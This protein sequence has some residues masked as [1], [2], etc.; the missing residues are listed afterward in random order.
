LTLKHHHF[1]WDYLIDILPLG[2]AGIA[3]EEMVARQRCL[4][5]NTIYS[6]LNI[7]LLCDVD[8]LAVSNIL[9]TVNLFGT[10]RKGEVMLTVATG[11]SLIA[12]FQ[13]TIQ[14]STVP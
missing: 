7:Y 9:L 2:W 8:Q 11:V 5:A 6:L 14:S 3:H 13:V 10:E 12:I 1:L 4:V